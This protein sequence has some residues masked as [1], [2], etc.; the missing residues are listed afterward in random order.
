MLM[1]LQRS[2]FIRNLGETALGLNSLFNSILSAISIADVGLDTVLVFVLFK[3]LEERNSDKITALLNFIKKIY[4][5][6]AAIIFI[7]GLIVIPLLP[8]II[9]GRN[10]TRYVVIIYLLYLVNTI[11][12]YTF[13]EYRVFLN[14]NQQSY[15]VS[16]VTAIVTVLMTLLQIIALV[17]FKSFVVFELIQILATVAMGVCFWIYVRKRVSLKKSNVVI[18][19]ADKKTILMNG[20]GGLSNRIGTFVV[21]GSDSV[22]LSIFSN[23]VNVARYSNYMMII[24]AAVSIVMKSV[25]A[26]MPS[27]GHQV[28]QQDSAERTTMFETFNH[29][30]FSISFTIFGI[31]LLNVNYFIGL[32]IGKNQIL[33]MGITTLLSVNLLIRLARLGPLNYID[34]LGLQWQQR[35]KPIVE[36]V[37]NLTA[38]LLLLSFFKLGLLGILLGTLISNLTTVVWMEPKVVFQNGVDLSRNYFVIVIRF[39]ILV[40]A[41]LGFYFYFGN[42][43]SKLTVP[44]FIMRG[45]I[46]SIIVIMLTMIEFLTS[47]DGIGFLKKLKKG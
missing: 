13:A 1:F 6:V 21:F 47:K 39:L 27:I 40:V 41:C 31:F 18:S 33:N 25:S 5:S 32:W 26:M 38:S 15:V 36:A 37:V 7:V 29:V 9:H 24:N 16:I 23:L 28:V 19:S 44:D 42:I 45:F 11:L 34:A 30:I 8:Y 14:A 4:L 20:I 46:S 12:T 3:P 35:W 22:L 10:V 43:P 2:F 17:V